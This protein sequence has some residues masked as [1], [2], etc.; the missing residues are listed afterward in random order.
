MYNSNKRA[1]TKLKEL[2]DKF[3]ISVNKRCDSQP[4][5]QIEKMCAT[6][7]DPYF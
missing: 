3:N 4:S 1:M 7:R 5:N 6:M 2:C